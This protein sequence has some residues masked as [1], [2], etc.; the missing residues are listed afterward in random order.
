MVQKSLKTSGTKA[1]KKIFWVGYP[2]LKA[3]FASPKIFFLKD[4]K[5][6]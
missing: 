2:G 6:I 3:R 1:P 4:A 5:S